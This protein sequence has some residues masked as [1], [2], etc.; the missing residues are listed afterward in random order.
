MNSRQ[1]ASRHSPNAAASATSKESV[2][3]FVL[4][5][6]TAEDFRAESKLVSGAARAARYFAGV[7][8]A[9]RPVGTH[10]SAKTSAVLR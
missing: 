5:G 1:P 9:G 8:R 6:N 7:C 4:N 2:S 3:V 10:R